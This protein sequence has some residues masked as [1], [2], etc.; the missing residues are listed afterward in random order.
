GPE[1]EFP[2]LAAAADPTRNAILLAYQSHPNQII[3]IDP[4]FQ[5]M[6]AI[7]LKESNATVAQISSTGGKS[8]VPLPAPFERAAQ[9]GF[10]VLSDGTIWL[11]YQP[12]D[13]AALT[14]NQVYATRY[15]NNAWSAPSLVGLKYMDG[16]SGSAARVPG[17]MVSQAGQPQ[18]AFLT[19]DQKIHT[20]V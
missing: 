9:F 13:H 5:I 10:S 7:F 18:V 20:F 4:L 12:I 14:W 8:F 17:F 6:N 11:T 3:F 16:N 2:F 15:Y 1:G 19:P